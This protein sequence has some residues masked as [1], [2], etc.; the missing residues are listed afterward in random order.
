MSEPLRRALAE[1]AVAL[2][3]RVLDEMYENPFWMERYGARGR[4]FANEDSLHHIAY[5]DQALASA[6]PLIFERYARW[7]R[8][9]L[10]TRGMCTEHLAENFRLLARA[11][12]DAGLPDEG[13]AREILLRG[14]ASLRYE[15]GDAGVLEGG[16]DQ[17]LRAVEE[18]QAAQP[19]RE[20]DRRY[21]VS[22]LVDAVATGERTFFEQFS[23]R[24]PDAVRNAL[25]QTSAILGVPYR[26]PDRPS[27]G[28]R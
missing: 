13:A 5:V 8:T 19:M 16:R 14:D 27:G 21:L 15:D 26:A 6:D 17:L 2:S 9:V 24:F 11:I 7:L 25:I 18:A 20:D 22:Y 28:D 23:A 3:Q 4:S 12:A 10:V 1:H